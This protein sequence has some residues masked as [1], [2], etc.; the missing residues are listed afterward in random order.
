V[1]IARQSVALVRLNERG[2]G[3]IMS[4][5]LHKQKRGSKSDDLSFI[6]VSE[7][8]QYSKISSRAWLTTGRFDDD[9]VSFAE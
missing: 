2:G 6:S 4:S 1:T 5:R 9:L 8:R 3:G 7:A